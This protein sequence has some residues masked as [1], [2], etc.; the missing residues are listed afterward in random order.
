MPTDEVLH[1]LKWK[2]EA[3]ADVQVWLSFQ[4]VEF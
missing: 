3:F 4:G 1:A 2:E